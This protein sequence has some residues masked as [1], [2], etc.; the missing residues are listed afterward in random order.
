MAVLK[1]EEW[2]HDARICIKIKSTHVSSN[3]L[4]LELF[5]EEQTVPSYW[6]ATLK[7][8]TRSN[9]LHALT[10]STEQFHF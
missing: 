2:E 7:A 8:T 4:Y 1:A 10:V 6:K 3:K 5:F 9:L